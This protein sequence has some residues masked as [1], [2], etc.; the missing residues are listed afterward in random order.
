MT[1][2]IPK[3]GGEKRGMA[4]EGGQ[5]L[6]TGCIEI[7]YPALRGGV[8]ELSVRERGEINPDKDAQ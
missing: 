6:T 1:L 4:Q 5:T 3:G 2:K 7:T 8:G